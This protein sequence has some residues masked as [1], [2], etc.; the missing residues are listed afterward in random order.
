MTQFL[1]IRI[2]V[3]VIYYGKSH[4]GQII[5]TMNNFRCIIKTDSSKWCKL[6]SD[7]N[8]MWYNQILVPASR[9]NPKY[10]APL[11]YAYRTD[12]YF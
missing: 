12:K 10:I 11:N 3:G 4:I 2:Q 1:A 7:R 5:E 6:E 8:G 9:R